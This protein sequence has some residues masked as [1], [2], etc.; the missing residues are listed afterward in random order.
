MPPLVIQ[1]QKSET[2]EESGQ[3]NKTNYPLEKFQKQLKEGHV[4]ETL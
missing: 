4:S 2:M 3:S 1:L